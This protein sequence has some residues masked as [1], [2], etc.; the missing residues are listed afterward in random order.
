MSGWPGV[1]RPSVWCPPV[2]CGTFISDVWS[3]GPGPPGHTV[4]GADFFGPGACPHPQVLLGGRVGGR[5]T[6]ARWGIPGVGY[7]GQVTVALEVD[8]ALI[9]QQLLVLA[10]MVPVPGS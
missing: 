5:P 8:A 9:A 3:V 7:D 2:W 6:G 1:W 4:S 10:C